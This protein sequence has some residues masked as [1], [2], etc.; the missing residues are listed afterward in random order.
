MKVSARSKSNWKFGND[1]FLVERVDAR[2]TWRNGF[3]ELRRELTIISGLTYVVWLSTTDIN[4]SEYSYR[5]LYILWSGFHQKS[6]QDYF[7][8][9]WHKFIYCP[10]VVSCKCFL[11]WFMVK[12]MIIK[13]E[14]KWI[15][16]TSVEILR[17][18]WLDSSSIHLLAMPKQLLFQSL[19]S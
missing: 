14:W 1:W 2:S 9:I 5:W 10:Y 18:S 17:S 19:K 11:F 7:L 15:V 4:G 13:V 8:S 16:Y 12:Q 6:F 3:S